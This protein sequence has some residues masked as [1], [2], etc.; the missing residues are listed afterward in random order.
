MKVWAAREGQTLKRRVMLSTYPSTL[1]LFD[2]YCP[3]EIRVVKVSSKTGK[4]LKKPF[5]EVVLDL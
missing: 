2:L 5:P 1:L 3:V 4:M